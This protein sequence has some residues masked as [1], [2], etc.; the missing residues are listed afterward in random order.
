MTLQH[1]CFENPASEYGEHGHIRVAEYLDEYV[2]PQTYGVKIHR[3][4]SKYLNLIT[5]HGC[6]LREVVEPQLTDPYLN[7]KDAHI[8]SYLILD[9]VKSI[10]GARAL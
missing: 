3:P 2:I 9:F 4:L 8:P 1:P 7:F 5:S 10:P 6:S